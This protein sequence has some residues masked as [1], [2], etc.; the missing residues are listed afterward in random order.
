MAAKVKPMGRQ[1]AKLKQEARDAAGAG[2]SLEKLAEKGNEIAKAGNWDYTFTTD[3]F[4]E[5]PKANKTRA[6]KATPLLNETP[7]P[8]ITP[9]GSN[10]GY[11]VNDIREVAALLDK[12]GGAR[13]VVELIDA[14]EPPATR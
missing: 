3:S 5:K 11:S 6:N 8:V 2:A 10:G 14:L 13:R 12:L 4:V 1:I 7:P 9:Q